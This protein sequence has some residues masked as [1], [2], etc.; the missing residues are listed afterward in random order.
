MVLAVGTRC[1]SNHDWS[2]KQFRAQVRQ[3]TR[4]PCTS[5]AF[6][7]RPASRALGGPGRDSLRPRTDSEDDEEEEEE[8][9]EFDEEAFLEEQRKARE[10]EELA[11]ALALLET[12]TQLPGKESLTWTAHQKSLAT[13]FIREA[14]ETILCCYLVRIG[15]KARLA[16]SLNLPVGPVGVVWYFLKLDPKQH[17]T[18]ANFKRW[19]SYGTLDTDDPHE[20]QHFLM[21][22]YQPVLLADPADPPVF[23]HYRQLVGLPRLI[24]LVGAQLVQHEGTAT[25]TPMLYVPPEVLALPDDPEK[26]RELP[27]NAGLLA[28]TEELVQHWVEQIHSFCFEQGDASSPL[29]LGLLHEI[30]QLSMKK[31]MVQRLLTLLEGPEYVKVLHYLEEE[32]SPVTLLI[33]QAIDTLKE[34]QR[35]QE[36]TSGQ[37]VHL[38]GPL[39]RL[40]TDSVQALTE[41]MY[42]VLALLRIIWINSHHYHQQ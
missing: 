27:L 38:E 17:I 34:V 18:A 41:H 31:D 19:V 39:E 28:R 26:R 42:D 29:E 32:S 16:V 15:G 11:E 23:G 21:E 1:H 37:L 25:G 3:D 9:E 10:E 36:E 33:G 30:R 12:L 6:A 22:V 4:T 14:N 24:N 20:V 7:R 5:R 13:S 35:R 8:E 2:A 40:Y